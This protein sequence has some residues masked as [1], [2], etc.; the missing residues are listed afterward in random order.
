MVTSLDDL[1]DDTLMDIFSYLSLSELVAIEL[2]CKKWHGICLHLWRTLKKVSLAELLN[3]KF[4]PNCEVRNHT[5]LYRKPILTETAL[6]S[7]AKRCGSTL[8]HLETGFPLKMDL[9]CLNILASDFP[10]LQ[11]MDLSKMLPI[12][13]E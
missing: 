12:S 9:N 5:P 7:L 10:K 11:S 4:I 13:S 2:V 6:R 3:V 1:P 8:R